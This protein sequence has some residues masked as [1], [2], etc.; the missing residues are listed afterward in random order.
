[1]ADR[2]T[3]IVTP[4]MVQRANDRI[5]ARQGGAADQPSVIYFLGRPIN[6]DPEVGYHEIS[7]A[8]ERINE[9]RAKKAV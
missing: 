9:R 1:M 2:N 3:F 8:I 4:R 6:V 7:E 5:M